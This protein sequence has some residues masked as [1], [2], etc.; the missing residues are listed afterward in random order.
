M[1]KFQVASQQPAIESPAIL[2]TRPPT[3]AAYMYSTTL[4]SEC[5]HSEHSNLRRS[6]RCWVGPMRASS[7]PVPHLGHGCRTIAFDSMVAG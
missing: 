5:S 1:Q 7:I 2:K 6:C 3:E 4:L